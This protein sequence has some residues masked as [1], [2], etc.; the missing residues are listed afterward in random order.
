MY[1]ECEILIVG[2]GTMSCLFR[3]KKGFES[4]TNTEA[5]L[6]DYILENKDEVINLSAHTM[7]EKAETSA[8]AVVRFAK[9]IGYKGFTELKIELAKDSDESKDK[10]DDILREKDTMEI[11]LK[12][13]A[14]Y[15]DTVIENTYKMINVNNLKKA[16]ETLKEARR[17]YIFGVG[18]SGIVAQDLVQKFSR[19]NVLAMHESDSHVQLA[20]TIGITP[21]DVCIAISYRGNTLEV[22]AATKQA[23]KNGAT[24]IAIT[25]FNKNPLG[26]MADIPLYIPSEESDIRYGAISSRDAFFIITDLLY[27]GIARDNFAKTKEHILKTRELILDTYK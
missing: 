1:R 11:L 24:T 2:R 15:K 10:I 8:A 13:T 3:I 5:R 7:G 21:E 23:K 9:K 6:A 4:Y 26:K 22:N 19:I 25:Q 17:I 16:V 27:L 18:N 20:A 14:G 12:K